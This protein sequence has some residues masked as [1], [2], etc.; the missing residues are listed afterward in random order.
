MY[1][2]SFC[3]E[4]SR[5]VGVVEEVGEEL[6]G[7]GGLDGDVCHLFLFFRARTLLIGVLF[8]TNVSLAIL[9]L[10]VFLAL[11]SLLELVFFSPS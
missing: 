11:S 4:A 2:I 6:R 5:S 8:F 7:Q 3:H 1:L 10:E 9:L